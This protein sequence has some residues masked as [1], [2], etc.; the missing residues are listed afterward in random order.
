VRPVS[1]RS[2]RV[3]VPVLICTIVVV[4]LAVFLGTAFREVEHT[5]VRSAEGRARAA[6]DQLAGL[7]A[8]QGQQRLLEIRR[9]AEASALQEFVEHPTDQN[10][11]AAR[12]SL[13]TLGV[14]GQAGAADSYESRSERSRCYARGW[15][16]GCQHT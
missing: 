9:A 8:Q 10:R 5:L 14:A 1:G 6:A 11:L 13:A 3:R 7:L 4:V 16:F 15:P 12:R 2:L